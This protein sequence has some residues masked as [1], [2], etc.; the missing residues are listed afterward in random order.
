MQSRRRS[1]W[2]AACRSAVCRCGGAE[3]GRPARGS[4][5]VSAPPRGTTVWTGGSASL[6]H[7]IHSF[8]HLHLWH[9]VIQSLSPFIHSVT[10]SVSHLFSQ[11]FIHS[12]IHSVFHSVSLSFCNSISQSFI[13]S[14]IHSVIHNFSHSFSH[15]FSH[16]GSLI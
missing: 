6:T 14:F 9:L 3:T 5:T 8:S 10:H 13:Q 4:E 12:I 11:S 1:C 7:F 16:Q 15:S 2:T